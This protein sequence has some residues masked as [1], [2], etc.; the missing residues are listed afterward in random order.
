MATTELRRVQASEMP[1]SFD[2]ISLLALKAEAILGYSGLR[3]KLGIPPASLTRVLE[4]LGIEPYRNEDVQEYKRKK[5][6][7]AEEQ[8]WDEFAKRARL[9][10]GRLGIQEP[11]GHV[12]VAGSFVHARWRKVPLAKYQGTVPE[13]ALSRAI[14]IK[15]RLPK[16]DFYVE[17]L[18][19]DKR[20]DPFLIATC[21]RER[22]YIDVWEERAF[23]LAYDDS[24]ARM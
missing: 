4:E 7:E 5:A 14:E 15:E 21:G 24:P 10:Q 20:Y 2:L 8:V 9:E 12:M 23:E 3:E 22:F 1:R 16:A 11:W 13:F 17:E 18:I 6:K 19:V